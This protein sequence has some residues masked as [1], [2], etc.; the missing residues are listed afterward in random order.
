MEQQQQTAKT[1][2]PKGGPKDGWITKGRIGRRSMGQAG[3]QVHCQGQFH[4]QGQVQGRQTIPDQVHV[5]GQVHFQGHYSQVDCQGQ[6]HWSSSSLQ[7]Q[8]TVKFKVIVM[9]LPKVTFIVSLLI[10][11]LYPNRAN[12]MLAF[13]VHGATA[14]SNSRLGNT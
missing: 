11:G 4:C 9:L 12:C 1:D 6:V 10:S 13:Q 14:D 8:F 2:S 5:Q 7:D 3:G